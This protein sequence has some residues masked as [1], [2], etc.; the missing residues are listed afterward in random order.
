MNISRM[1]FNAFEKFISTGTAA[2]KLGSSAGIQR[3]EGLAPHSSEDYKS[4]TKQEQDKMQEQIKK[5]NESIVASGRE[6]Q[7]KYNEEV[8]Q[9]YV[10]IIDS[11]TKEVLSS[12]PPEF[13]IDLSKKMKDM[14]GMFFD[15]KL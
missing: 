7:F 13:L 8:Q 6:L 12:L 2:F 1:D 5:L 3:E 10:E 11:K 14:I 9:L 15:E 4:L